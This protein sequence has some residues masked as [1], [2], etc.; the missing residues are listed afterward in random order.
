M[1]TPV[2]SLGAGVQSS[3]MLLMAAEGEFGEVPPLA[4]F[5]DTQHEPAAVYEHLDWLEAQ[6][7]GRIEVA[8][9]SH[10]DLLEA[11][12]T[13]TFNPIPLYIDSPDG[14]GGVGRRQCTKEFKLFP[15]R[16]ELRRRGFGE[17]NPVDMWV[18]ISLDESLRMKATGLKWVQNTWPL[19]DRRMSRQDCLRWFGERYP[20]RQLA[21]SACVFC[22]YKRDRE[23][24]LMRHE[25]PESFALA[26]A[27]DEAMRDGVSG[28]R[29]YVSRSLRPLAEIRSVE[30]LG[31]QAFDFEAEC[32]GMCGV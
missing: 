26:V 10:G 29:Q 5:A 4:V 2:I 7:A 23:F 6:V 1:R 30:D 18:G 21:K 31:Q 11:A 32:E 12:T 22:P 16:R 24:A 17:D 27:A 15:I 20:D 14:R 25:D 19:I 8:R 13:G 3:T 9:V 28:R